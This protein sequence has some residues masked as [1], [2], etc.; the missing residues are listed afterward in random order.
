M[1]VSRG[2]VAHVAGVAGVLV[3][4]WLLYSPGLSADFLLDDRPNLGGLTAVSDSSSAI[5]FAFSG[6]AGPTGRPV[7]LLSFALQADQWGGAARPFLEVNLFI[8][9]LNALL[10]WGFFAQL[11]RSLKFGRHDAMLI[12]LAAVSLWALMPL[13]ASST[14]M[15]IQR[16][17]TLAAT[18]ML[19]GLNVYLVFRSRLDDAPRTALVGMSLA[20]GIATLLAVLSKENGALLPTLVLVVEATLLGRPQAVSTRTWRGWQVVVLG[21]PSAAIA[22]LL[23]SRVPY[24]AAT[25]AKWDFSAGERLL[26]EARVL[27]DYAFNAALPRLTAFGPFH[28]DYAVSRRLFDPG[29]LLAVAGWLAAIGA[30]L[31]LRRRYPLYAF[32][33]LWFAAG[34][35]VE[36]TTVPLFLYFEHRNYVPMLG[37]AFA[38]S[39]ALFS[40]TG[41]LQLPARLLLPVLAVLN[42]VILFGVTS[43]WG[44]PAVAAPFWASIAPD[45][46]GATGFFVQQ[47]IQGGDPA[48]AIATLAEFAADHPEHAYLGLPALTLACSILPG[49][50]HRDRARNLEPQLATMRYG[51]F[52][53]SQLDQLFAATRQKPCAGVDAATVR[54]LA[55]AVYGNPRYRNVDAYASLHYQLLARIAFADGNSSEALA[56]LEDARRYGGGAELDARIVSVLISERDFTG[57]RDYV[58]QAEADLPRHPF[59]R[60]AA[61]AMLEELRRYVDEAEAAAGDGP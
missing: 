21:V 2:F 33:V 24:D 39:A 19:L 59:R 55:D 35:L 56:R 27:W 1:P 8:H 47:Q 5:Q 31:F 60:V 30:A 12:A 49:E 29:T 53:A 52:V 51:D 4:A 20:V 40:V 18:W 26:T 9:L 45:S 46:P 13:L 22:V 34:H 50:D 15:V 38:L 16:M 3:I 17:T 32:G 57:A 61:S 48:G 14:L 44:T 28:D 58:Q 11:A 23:L 54:G 41:R 36:S 6:D 37:P 10:A 7:S 42:G 25:I 43:T